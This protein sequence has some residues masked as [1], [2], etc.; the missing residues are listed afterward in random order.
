VFVASSTT[1]APLRSGELRLRAFDL[2]A[3]VL[4]LAGAFE[5]GLCVDGELDLA[6]GSGIG[7]TV[8]ESGDATWGVVRPHVT[9]AYLVFSHFALRADLGVGLALDRPDFTSTGVGA[10]SI[11]QPG[12]ATVRASLGVEA[13]F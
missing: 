13:R 7:E 1:S 10:G 6:L 2:G 12:E 8:P 11:A 9:A 3:C 5:L 4:P